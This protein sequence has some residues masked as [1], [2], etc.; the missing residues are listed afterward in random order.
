MP[1]WRP[2]TAADLAGAY[3]L[4]TRSHPD[5]PERRDVLFEKFRLFPRGC[6][7]L[8]GPGTEIA[9]YCFSHPWQTGAPPALDTMLQVL[10][11]QPAAYFIHDVTV[12]SSLRRMNLASS[13]VPRLV[14]IARSIPV[15][16]MT[17]VAVSGSEP[18]W[19]RSGF[20]R[21]ADEGLQDAARRKYGAGAVHMTR[22]TA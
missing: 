13:L 15:G 14:E 21:T 3:D 19:A 10:P 4:S 17:L 16:H 1:Q 5:F 7:V 8:D 9:G 11:L 20:R 2:M 6:F 22:D 18:F 12:D